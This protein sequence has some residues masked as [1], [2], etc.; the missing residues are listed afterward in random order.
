MENI[1][2]GFGNATPSCYFDIDWRYLDGDHFHEAS[3]M[4]NMHGLKG[5]DWIVGILG[6]EN[7]RFGEGMGIYVYLSSF[8]KIGPT[9]MHSGQRVK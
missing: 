6:L 1:S 4:N 3:Q 7:V 5:L 8:F 9:M 2:L